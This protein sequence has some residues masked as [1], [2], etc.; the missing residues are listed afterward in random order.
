MRQVAHIFRKDFERLWLLCALVAVETILHAFYL[1]KLGGMTGL[2]VMGPLGII[3]LFA[4]LSALVLPVVVAVMT[5]VVIQ[6]EPLTGSDAFWLTRP[7][8][9][10]ALLTEKAAFVALFGLAPLALHDV[11]AVAWFGLAS[12]A[13][14][15]VITME[16]IEFTMV[17]LPVAASAVLTP[18]FG[19][20]AIAGVSMLF[21]FGLLLSV[22]GARM[23][24]NWGLLASIP[25]MIEWPL[26]AATAVAMVVYQ[27]RTR[28]TKYSA[29]MGVA[30]LVAIA[31]VLALFRFTFAWGFHD[32]LEPPAPGL[33]QVRV[34]PTFDA[35]NAVLSERGP[36][37]HLLAYP[38]RVDGLSDGISIQEFR[39]DSAVN[40]APLAVLNAPEFRNHTSAFLLFAGGDD[41][42]VRNRNTL[43]DWRGAIYFQAYRDLPKIRVPVSDKEVEV[44]ISR[45]KCKV[46]SRLN[47]PGNFILS[48]DCAELEPASGLRIEAVL[49]DAGGQ[50]IWGNST[51]Q[52]GLG[53]DGH[54]LFPAM[55]NPVHLSKIGVDLRRVDGQNPAT[56]PADA[57]VVISP[58]EPAGLIRRDFHISGVR[59]ADL[60]YESWKLRGTANFPQAVH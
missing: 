14:L 41:F 46:T 30:G 22:L 5:V 12:P 47:Y 15:P 28:R 38:F 59:L 43:V 50:A 32:R 1:T 49:E 6:A 60:E 2:F 20:F 24:A 29:A 34:V 26:A 31:L 3:G 35:S 23:E 16:T 18:G 36:Q 42:Q 10:A 7:Y 39:T 27:Y 17:L 55:M 21:S 52:S 33:E 54:A 19:R 48:L 56:I 51:G 37:K 53:Q 4:V 45:E 8:S 40:S 58:K 9:R 11:F 57:T 25:G 13:A 44:T